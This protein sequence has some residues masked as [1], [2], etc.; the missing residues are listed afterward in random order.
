MTNLNKPEANTSGR[1]YAITRATC[2]FSSRLELVAVAVLLCVWGTSVL[3][4]ARVI[5]LRKH[6]AYCMYQADFPHL[7]LYHSRKSVAVR[8]R[9]G[10]HVLCSY[11]PLGRGVEQA[12]SGQEYTS[13]PR[14]CLAQSTIS[15][16]GTDVS[17][18]LG[19]KRLISLFRM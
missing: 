12:G 5:F 9:A 15:K 19:L 8:R 2:V 17:F 14:P 10:R 4:A 11:F 18:A 13:P 3:N 6:T 16:P 1:A 7:P